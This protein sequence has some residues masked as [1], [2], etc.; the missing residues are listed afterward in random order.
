[1]LY[2][3][4]VLTHTGVTTATPSTQQPM[5]AP[6]GFAALLYGDTDPRGVVLRPAGTSARWLTRPGAPLRSLNHNGGLMNFTQVY[7]E[8]ARMA[9][10]PSVNNAMTVSL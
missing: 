10:S 4:A 3:V 6:P 5:L 1:M 9:T 2:F 7:V 8:I